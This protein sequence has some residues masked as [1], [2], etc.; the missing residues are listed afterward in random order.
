MSREL[1]A[2]LAAN[3]DDSVIY[4]FFAIDM[5]FDT[6]PI[7]SWTG[8]GNISYGGNEYIGT[9]NLLNFSS[10]EE[11]TEISVK[12][13]TVSLSGIPSDLL[14]LALATPYQGRVCNIYFG[15]ITRTTSPSYAAAGL[16]PSLVADFS[17][18]YYYYL[19]I[20]EPEILTYDFTPI[21]SG[22]MDQMNIEEG[23]E[24]CSIELKV[25]NKLIDLERAR[26]ARFTSGFQ[27]SLFPDD[28]GLDFVESL[29]DR[30][31]SWGK[32]TKSSGSTDTTTTFFGAA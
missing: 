18:M 16:E 25:E 6:T 28:L 4:P 21:F 22:Y 9:G 19:E 10:V 1:P 11:T 31:I 29:Q 30:P 7:R 5:L 13:A 27:K 3:L 8:L 17:N 24:T 2:N 20:P 23:P 15:M 14:S 32:A 26:V 12:G